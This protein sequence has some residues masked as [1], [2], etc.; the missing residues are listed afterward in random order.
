[1][2]AQK[3]KSNFSEIEKEAEL[4]DQMKERQEE[5]AKIDKEKR[6]EN[7]ERQV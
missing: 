5:Q 7:E 2:G 1:M 3:V 6:A 4:N